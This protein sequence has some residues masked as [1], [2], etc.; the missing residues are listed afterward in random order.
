MDL[1]VLP[2]AVREE[3]EALSEFHGPITGLQRQTGS[4]CGVVKPTWLVIFNGGPDW[5]LTGGGFVVHEGQTKTGPAI[6]INDDGTS[7]LF[8][9][10]DPS[11]FLSEILKET[12]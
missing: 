12:R 1:T 8:M 5:S 7:P 6:A 4:K 10:G 2:D 9:D 11:P 3:A